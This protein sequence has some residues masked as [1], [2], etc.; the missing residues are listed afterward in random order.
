[1]TDVDFSAVRLFDKL[2]L[3]RGLQRQADFC[4]S[5]ECGFLA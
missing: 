1:M 4:V 2:F 5:S 3:R